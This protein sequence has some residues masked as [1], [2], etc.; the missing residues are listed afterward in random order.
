LEA[1]IYLRS[2]GASPGTPVHADD[3][4]AWEIYWQ[5]QKVGWETVYR[6]RRLDQ[7]DAY[8]ADWL[9]TRLVTLQEYVHAH[10]QAT[11]EQR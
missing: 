2:H 9:L 5:A 11:Q 7:L 8:S 6:L 3:V 1:C 4:Q 10:N